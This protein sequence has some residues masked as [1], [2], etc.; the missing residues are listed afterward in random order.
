MLMS[1]QQPAPAALSSSSRSFAGLLADFAAP[2]NKLPPARDLDGLA[3]DVATLSYEQALRRRSGSHPVPDQA[4]AQRD[5]KSTPTLKR[6]IQ[7]TVE[8]TASGVTAGPPSTSGSQTS[9][10]RCSSVTVRISATESEQL[11]L[12]AAEAGL[13]I[14]A[15][16]RSCAFEVETLRAEVKATLTQLRSQCTPSERNPV[17]PVPRRPWLRLLTRAIRTKSR[18]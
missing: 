13:T 10:R 12:R 8:R 2:E 17:L 5:L 1:M 16:L 11:H 3:D 4:D 6:P 18:P 14:S 7:P 15:Y 9:G